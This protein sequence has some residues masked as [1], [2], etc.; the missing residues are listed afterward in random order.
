MSE[1]QA[2]ARRVLRIAGLRRSVRILQRAID[3]YC[4]ALGFAV[5]ER[6]EPASRAS[7]ALGSE[8]IELVQVAPASMAP[9]AIAP[10][11]RF[12]HAAIVAAD[13]DAA[14]G[15]LRAFAPVPISEG[16]P[17]RLPAASGG[18]TAFKFRDP[19][20]HPLEL[21]HFPA[22]AGDARW[23]GPAQAAPTFGIDHFAMVVADVERSIAFYA[24]YGLRVAS[25][26]VNRGIEQSR[27]DGMP[28]AVVDV[29]ALEAAAGSTPHLEL[30]GYRR[31]PAAGS[32]RHRP[33]CHDSGR[34]IIRLR[35]A[36]GDAAGAAIVD[37]DGHALLITGEVG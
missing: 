17:Q 32:S 37:P 24:A 5:V 3:F 13:M 12:Q 8:H 31:P 10:D 18:A 21:I 26:Q 23:Q 1:A 35:A 34:D 4:G 19:D 14:W 15:R 2:F 33:A 16:G 36:E 28:E 30:L 29:V 9:A 27:L 7:L 25:R 11:P 6:G 20:G 22:G